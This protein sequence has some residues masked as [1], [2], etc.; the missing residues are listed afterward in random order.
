MIPIVIT[1]MDFNQLKGQ[2]FQ[3]ESMYSAGH[4]KRGDCS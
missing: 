3:E 1:G 2:R 4:G